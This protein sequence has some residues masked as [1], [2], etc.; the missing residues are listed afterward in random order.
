VLVKHTP[1]FSQNYG[2]LSVWS[3]QGMEKSHHAAKAA[4]Q[5]HTQNGGTNNRISII[6]QQY[7]HWYRNIQHRFVKKQQVAAS[8]SLPKDEEVVAR[9][10]RRSAA[11]K[12]PS[13]VE[14]R[15]WWRQTRVRKCSVWSQRVQQVE[16]PESDHDVGSG[17][18]APNTAST[19]SDFDQF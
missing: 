18:D 2:S 16:I 4:T 15:N 3:C 8:K 5:N 12:A 9:F 1:W 13:I 10:L 7:E 14:G 6:I 17:A 19:E 11:S